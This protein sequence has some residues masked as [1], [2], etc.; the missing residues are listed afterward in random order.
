MSTMLRPTAL[1]TALCCSCSWI[2]MEAPKKDWKPQHG[3]PTCSTG[4]GPVVVD[5]VILTLSFIGLGATYTDKTATDADKSLALLGFGLDALTFG[6]SAGTGAT[7]S[8]RCQK[9]NAEFAAFHGAP[10]PG[11]AL[12][13]GDDLRD[14]TPQ[15][16]PPRVFYCSSAP[17]DSTVGIC[18]SDAAACETGQAAIVAAAG[19]ATPCAIAPAAVCFDAGTAPTALSCY[20]TIGSCAKALDAAKTSGGADANAACHTLR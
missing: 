11:P 12:V 5:I 4:S 7:W 18:A 15:I 20:P 19:D 9:Q 10:P 17:T 8:K 16:P 1:V 2:V 3:A 13:G 14:R 6:I